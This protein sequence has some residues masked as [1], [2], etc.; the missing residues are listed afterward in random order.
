MI[1]TIE[2]PWEVGASVLLA[3]AFLWVLYIIA[4]NDANESEKLQ[5]RIDHYKPEEKKDGESS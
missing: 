2:D 3:L 1:A 4:T 5:Y